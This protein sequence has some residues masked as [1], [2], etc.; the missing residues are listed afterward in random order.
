[1]HENLPTDKALFEDMYSNYN[2][3]TNG[4]IARARAGYAAWNNG[5]HM[6]GAMGTAGKCELKLTLA[7][8]R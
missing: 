8:R 7:P 2:R 1:M 6:S 4:T 5:F 3:L